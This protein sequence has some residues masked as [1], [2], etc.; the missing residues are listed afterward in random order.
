[1]DLEVAEGEVFGYLGPNG[2]G[3]TTTIRLLLN[4][5]QPTRGGAAVFGR[6]VVKDSV[7]VRR[8][9]GYLP[10]GLELY[11]NLTG[12]EFLAFAARLRGG[13]DRQYVN[14]L[15]ERLK[16]EPTARIRTLSHGNRQKLGLVQAFMHQP[17]LVILD[18]PTSGLDPLVQQEFY[19]LLAETKKAG[20]TVFLSTHVLSEAERACDRVGII[21]NGRLAAIESIAGLKAKALRRLEIR[22]GGPVPAD[23]FSGI[24]G[25]RDVR[26]D[27]NTLE[28]TATGEPDAL[29]KA[30]AQYR[31]VDIISREP[32]LEEIFLTYY[33]NGEA[34]R[35]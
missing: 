25:I 2:A 32:G 30:A 9:T 12:R 26:F 4:F 33:G 6:D 16:C 34:G 15:L 10:G 1:M 17:R 21:R 31:I 23:R 13:V 14:D 19:A 22:F 24:P 5:I 11:G 18:E 7:A 8:D 35:G 3:K 28:C 20:R 27:G 29:I